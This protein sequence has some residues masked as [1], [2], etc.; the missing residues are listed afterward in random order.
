MGFMI[1]TANA[2][3][4][5]IESKNI[6]KAMDKTVHY[7]RQQNSVNSYSVEVIYAE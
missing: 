4:V 5:I 3:S 7:G 1:P 6:T 2:N